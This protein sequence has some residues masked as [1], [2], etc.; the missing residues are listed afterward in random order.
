MRKLRAVILIFFS[1]CAVAFAQATNEPPP[2]TVEAAEEVTLTTT[3]GVWMATNGVVLHYQEV[4]LS[5]QQASVNETTGEVMAQGNVRLQRGLYLVVADKIHYNF[6]TKR[7]I[8]D[9]FRFGQ[10]PLFV[11]SD[12]MVADQ[13]AN[14]YVGA[15][16]MITTDDFTQPRYSIHAKTLVIVPGEYVVAKHATVRIGNVPVFY[17]PYYRRT[18]RHRS[19]HFVFTPGY[20][21]KFGP[22]LL[23]TYDWYLGEKVEGA[24]HLDGRV[25]RG[26]GVGSDLDWHLGQWSDGKFKYYHAEDDAPGLD[27]NGKPIPRGRERIWF[28]DEATIRS[29]LTAKVV[30][31]H[32]SDAQMVRDFFESEYRKN[33]QPNS[34]AEVN[35]AWSNFS[36]DVLAQPRVD[37]FFDLVE[38]LPDLRLSAFRQQIG[39]TPLFYESESSFGYFRQKF[40]TGSTNLAYAAERGDTFHQIVLP[41]T[42]FD[43]LNVIP[44][45]GGRF[46][47]YS[48]AEGPGATTA[49]HNR[50]VFNTGAEI[51][52]KASQVWP[53]VRS[54][55]WEINGLRHIIQPSL[56]Y[57]FVPSPS[58]PLARLPQFD[59]LLPSTRLQAIEF[60]DF[61]AIDAIDSANVLRLALRN[62]LQTKR[63]DG[64]ENVVNWALYTDWRL[65]P[66]VG[67]STFA[68]W[69]SDLDLKPFHWLTF[70]SELRYEPAHGHW[71]EANHTAI[72]APTD[73]WNIAVGH[74]YLRPDPSFGTNSGNNLI[75]ASVFYRFNENWAARTSHHF[76]AR[77]GTMEEQFYTLY[78]DLR[79]WTASVTLRLRD[80]RTQGKDFTV[81]VAFSLKAFPRFGLGADS[82]DPSLLIGR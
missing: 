67:Q 23:G 75:F 11:Q 6:L 10:P 22:F 61:N 42:F 1:G 38:R 8:G 54:S 44:R 34:F 27:P 49:E 65:K 21:S 41:W 72:L 74:R 56:N 39:P 68:D 58:V 14:V 35:Q 31:R 2:I 70:N 4:V 81:A 30:I 12:V 62:K 43:W 19:N 50:T 7:I 80:N 73:E 77:D 71:R 82:N 33:V 76:E 66:H 51:T 28:R 5:A 64:V 69:F 15:E 63:K 26:L 25:K 16:G 17:F 55:F 52:A 18:L 53:G 36:L 3:N 9:N 59:T 29:N 45:A 78:R 37:P 40:G 60:P 46:T 57:V 24:I 47:H 48:E 13:A 79:S 20:Q 32:Q